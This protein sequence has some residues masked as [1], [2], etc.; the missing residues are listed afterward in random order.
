MDLQRNHDEPPARNARL[1]VLHDGYASQRGVASSVVYV[2]DGN[3]RVVVDPGMVRDR[4]LILDPLREAGCA[5]EEV[6]DVIFSHHHPDHTLHAAL[7]PEAR[8][9]DWWAVYE[10]DQ[11][12]SRPADR[13]TLGSSIRLLETP[14]HTREDI[15]TVVGTPDGI[16]VCSHL[17]WTADGPDEDPRGLDQTQ[18]RAGR[19]RVLAIADRV[20]PGHGPAFVPDESTPR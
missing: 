17:W 11:W 1:V 20:V 2:E 15:S 14:G 4:A 6:T 7:F 12:H 16:V 8:F 18:I 9:H 10:G 3:V 13:A 19:K 5:P